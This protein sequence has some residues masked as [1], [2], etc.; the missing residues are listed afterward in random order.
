ML[1]MV[2]NRHPEAAYVEAKQ[3]HEK[4][5]QDVQEALNGHRLD[6]PARSVRQEFATGDQNEPDPVPIY[7][8][9]SNPLSF[10]SRVDDELPEPY[11]TGTGR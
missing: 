11:R 8:L 10:A 9:I 1:V 7:T 4:L 5:A 3:G 6:D 2:P